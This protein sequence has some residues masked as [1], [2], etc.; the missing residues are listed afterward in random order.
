LNAETDQ[1]TREAEIVKLLTVI[2]FSVN[3]WAQLRSLP[4]RVTTP[5]GTMAPWRELARLVEPYTLFQ[6]LRDRP[7]VFEVEVQK[8][9]HCLEKLRKF[10][11]IGVDGPQPVAL[12][13]QQLTG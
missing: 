8:G 3:R 7:E 13:R 10:H 2:S 9:S 5:W 6:F 4:Y 1:E 12:V 11:C